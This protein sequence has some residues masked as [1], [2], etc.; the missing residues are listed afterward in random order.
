MEKIFEDYFSEAQADMVA[1]TLEYVDKKADY[2]YIYCSFESMYYFDFFYLINHQYI[3]RNE[4]NNI[5]IDYKYDTSSNRQL[6]A[7][8]IG[9]KN[10]KMIHELCQ[11]Y[12]REMPTEIKLIYNVQKNSLDA[13]YSYDLKYSN[14]KDLIADDIFTQWFEEVKKENK[15]ELG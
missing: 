1:I 5:G 12:N 8:K 3:D 15:H 4:L 7:M 13:E 6:Q 11:R 14:T 10:L 9:V 2:I